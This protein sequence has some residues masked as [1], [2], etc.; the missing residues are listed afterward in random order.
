MYFPLFPVGGNSVIVLL[1]SVFFP[2]DSGEI[3][4]IF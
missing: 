4:R 1:K 3:I 2:A